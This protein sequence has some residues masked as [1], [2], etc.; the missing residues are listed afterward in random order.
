MFT[1]MVGSSALG[2]RNE[3]LSL[4]L[5]EEQKKLITPALSRHNGA[6]VK[7][8]RSSRRRQQ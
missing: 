5:V 6:E 7:T 3:T 4:A 1:D 8:D 2:Q